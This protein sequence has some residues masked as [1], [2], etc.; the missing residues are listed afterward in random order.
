MHRHYV[1][2]DL[3]LLLVVG[4]SFARGSRERDHL[5][6]TEVDMPSDPKSTQGG[7]GSHQNRSR[8]LTL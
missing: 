8:H 1:P 6:S 5:P 4:R 3:R 7:S 2:T